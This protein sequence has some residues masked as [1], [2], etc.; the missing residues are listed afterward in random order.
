[1]GFKG[2]FNWASRQG[3]LWGVP[4]RV[5]LSAA[6]LVR[7]LTNISAAIPNAAQQQALE[8]VGELSSEEK[9][10]CF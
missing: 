2:V 4:L 1:V 8:T 7:Y 5:G 3:I 10:K 6:M 9:M